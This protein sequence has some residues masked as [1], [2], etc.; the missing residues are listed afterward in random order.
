MTQGHGIVNRFSRQ[1]RL[2]TRTDDV[3]V[4]AAAALQ[5]VEGLAC[6]AEDLRG[7]GVHLR[8]VPAP[9]AASAHVLHRRCL[10]V[11]LT[12]TI[13]VHSLGQ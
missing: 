10:F 8:F 6:P 5:L 11:T 3:A 2:A 13:F 4:I 9:L 12:L 7:L 1:R